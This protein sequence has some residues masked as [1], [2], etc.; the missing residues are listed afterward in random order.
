MVHCV[1]HSYYLLIE[2]HCKVA[3]FYAVCL[4]TWYVMLSPLASAFL[5]L[6]LLLSSS[7]LA[8]CWSPTRPAVLFLADAS[9]CL[10]VWDL[11]DRSHG[12]CLVYNV[13]SSSI[14]SLSLNTNHIPHHS[15]GAAAVAGG[16]GRA[17]GPPAAVDGAAN[18]ALAGTAAAVSATEGGSAAAGQAGGVDLAATGAAAAGGHGGGVQY[19]GIQQ[20]LAVGDSTGVLHL[21]ELPRTLRRPLANEKK[22]L[23]VF[24]AR[25]AAR[26]A[27]VASRQVSTAIQGD[28]EPY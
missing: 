14:M 5:Q 2:T 7:Y 9:G 4:S 27:D 11:L 12:P 13:A 8:A 1:L 25:E 15:S 18:A 26:V 3:S 6:L 24:V 20:L 16:T 28:N 21:L 17:P 23:A 22:Q 10:Q 19:G